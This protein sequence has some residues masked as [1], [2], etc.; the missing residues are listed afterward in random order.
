MVESNGR[1]N[2]LGLD[3][4]E[5]AHRNCLWLPYSYCRTGYL[6]AVG[7]PVACIKTGTKRHS[8]ILHMATC[9]ADALLGISFRGRYHAPRDR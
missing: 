1:S 2:S 8:L 7:A 3:K 6:T 9:D 5:T 4:R